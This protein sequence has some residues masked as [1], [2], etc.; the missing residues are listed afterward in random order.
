VKDQ[1]E[2]LLP[3]LVCHGQITLHTAQQAL[4]VDWIASYRRF[5]DTDLPLRNT[6]ALAD[7]DELE[8][9]RRMVVAVEPRQ[10]RAP[11]AGRSTLTFAGFVPREMY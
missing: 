4:A 8:F 7:D 2:N 10:P 6:A 1:L 3:Q 5:F 9:E 11:A